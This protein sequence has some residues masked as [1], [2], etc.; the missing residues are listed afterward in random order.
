MPR[1]VLIGSGAGPIEAFPLH[2]PKDIDNSALPLILPPPQ[3]PLI[4]SPTKRG[5]ASD[6]KQ[7]LKKRR[8]NGTAKSPETAETV[9]QAPTE[10][11]AGEDESVL[12]QEFKEYADAVLLEATGY[13]QISS[14]VCV[15]QGWDARRSQATVGAL[16]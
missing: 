3:A 8:V 1:L 16:W 10:I 6:V 5:R 14:D 11:S 12:S 2:P 15:V 4:Q 13:I 7:R 9:F